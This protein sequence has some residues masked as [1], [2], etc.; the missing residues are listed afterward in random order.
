MLSVY[1][2][3]TLHWERFVVVYHASLNGPMTG[4]ISK[5]K[6]RRWNMGVVE[7][8]WKITT[9]FAQTNKCECFTNFV[10]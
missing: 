7:T 6:K 10:L 1:F 9:A 3:T 2:I 4:S 8:I 5:E